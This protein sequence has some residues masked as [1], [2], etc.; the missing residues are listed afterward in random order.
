MYQRPCAP[1]QLMPGGLIDAYRLVQRLV[2]ALFQVVIWV[3]EAWGTDN[4]NRAH[5]FP[6]TRS[7]QAGQ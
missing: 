6:M 1:G 5:H 7:R 3:H 2:E 4:I